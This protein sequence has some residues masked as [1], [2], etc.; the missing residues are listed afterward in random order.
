MSTIAKTLGLVFL[1]ASFAYGATDLTISGT[2][3]DPSGAPFKGAFVQA[4]NMKTKIYVNVLSDKQGRYQ[5]QALQPG[6]YEVLAKAVGFKSEPREVKL[7]SSESLSLDFA[8][9]K[10]MV[11]WSDLSVYQGKKL[12]PDGKGKQLIAAE[13]FACHGF[14]SRMAATRRDADGWAQAV[15]YMR[16]VRRARLGNHVDDQAAATIISYLNDT[17]GV[18]SKLPKSPTEMPGYQ[19]TLR[20]CGD[21]A[22]KIVYVEY[23]MPGPNRMPFSAAPDKDGKIWI[24]DFGSGN[25]IGKLHPNTGEIEEFVAPNNGTAGLHSAL[26]APDRSVWPRPP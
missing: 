8:L 16:D 7:A 24:P 14:Q 15:N 17:F 18:D 10:A 5:I 19:D 6:E 23:D 20:P 25:R 9:E 13:C 22:M 11:R 4:Q 12:L 26:P 1:C 21:E 3:K 2:V